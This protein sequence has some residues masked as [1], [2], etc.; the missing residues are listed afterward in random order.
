MKHIVPLI[1]TVTLVACQPAFINGVPNEASPYFTVPV[2]SK[3][4][5]R[6]AVTAPAGEA[7]IYF[8]RGRVARWNEVNIYGAYC[9]LKLAV[10]R[11][12]PQTINPDEFIVRNVSQERRFYLGYAPL[13]P[14]IHVAALGARSIADIDTQGSDGYEILATVMQ[15]QSTRQPDV[16]QLACADWSIPQGLHPITVSKIRQ[17]LGESSTLHIVSPSR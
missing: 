12:V 16:S 8:Q 7:N 11:D 14:S 6:Q 2:D 9:V 4:V 17:T 13:P 5:L 3:L 1:F 10:K 15:L